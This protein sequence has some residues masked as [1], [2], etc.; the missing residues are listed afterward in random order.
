MPRLKVHEPPV[1]VSA[2]PARQYNHE[3]RTRT[4]LGAAI[5]WFPAYN[6]GTKGEALNVGFG[7][8]SRKDT[9][10]VPGGPA[11]WAAPETANRMLW[12]EKY[13]GPRPPGSNPFAW[14]ESSSGMTT[15]SRFTEIAQKEKENA[16]HAKA[17]AAQAETSTNVVKGKYF[18]QLTGQLGPPFSAPKLAPGAKHPL[19]SAMKK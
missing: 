18:D 6:D 5:H 3:D 15:G 13:I 14:V 4:A 1:F 10:A 16:A 12:E 8:V 7:E 2:S 11:T 17:A 19:L 9:R